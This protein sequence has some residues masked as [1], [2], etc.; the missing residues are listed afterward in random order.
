MRLKKEGSSPGF[1]SGWAWLSL[2]M[3]NNLPA[4][5]YTALFEIFS[6]FH[7]SPINFVIFNRESLIQVPDGDKNYKILTFSHDFQTTLSKEFIQFTSNGQ[8][9]EITFQ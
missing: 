8:P 3:T 9:G 5:T 6:G 7:A 2:P 1:S 4:G